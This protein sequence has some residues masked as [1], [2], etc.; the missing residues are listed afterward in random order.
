[1]RDPS[2]RL[3]MTKAESILKLSS[4]PSRRAASPLR[5]IRRLTRPS[6]EGRAGALVGPLRADEVVPLLLGQ[7]A[8]GDLA[9]VGL[10]GLK[11]D[12]PQPDTITGTGGGE[13]GTVRAERHAVDPSSMTDEWV[14]ERL[15]GLDIPQPDSLVGA[16]RG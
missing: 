16:S 14:A 6:W 12:I 7:V 11:A 10:P 4:N 13:S 1:M 2:L 3:R 8:P 9:G 15:V 5:R